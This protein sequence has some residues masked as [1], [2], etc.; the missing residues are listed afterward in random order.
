MLKGPIFAARESDAR[1]GL[2]ANDS[3]PQRSSPQLGPLQP[4]S[5]FRRQG[6]GLLT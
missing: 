3:E 2:G 5:N 6:V 1:P 4:T